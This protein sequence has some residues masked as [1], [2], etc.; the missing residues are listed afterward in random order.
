MHPPVGGALHADQSYRYRHFPQ[1][2]D[3]LVGDG[4]STKFR[5]GRPL[6]MAARPGPEFVLLAASDVLGNERL[7]IPETP[8]SDPTLWAVTRAPSK[9]KKDLIGDLLTQR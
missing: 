9:I 6:P 7:G 3:N 5:A 2:L 1:F 4:S 8:P